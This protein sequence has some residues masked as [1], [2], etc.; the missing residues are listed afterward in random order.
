MVKH[1]FHDEN[2]DIELNDGS[3]ISIRYVYELYYQLLCYFASRLI[4]DKEESRDIV[5]DIFIK[6]YKKKADFDN[7]ANVKSFLF[8]ATRNACLDYLKYKQKQASSKNEF[9][10]LV[11]KE[12]TLPTETIRIKVLEGIYHQIEMLPS[13]SRKIIR[14]IFID[15]KTTAE[16]A[17]EMSLSMQTV[18]NHKSRAVRTLRISLSAKNI[19]DAEVLILIYGLLLLCA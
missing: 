2:W 13:Q 1:D 4:K 17:A 7:I 19:F 5:I 3:N 6:L 16:V 18:L 14:S 15:G 11:T 9:S 8:V 12:E 10:Y